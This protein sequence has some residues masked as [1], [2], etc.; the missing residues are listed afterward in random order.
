M[1]VK[2]KQF[3]LA[4]FCF[5]SA[6]LAI[7]AIIIQY[8][9]VG[10]MYTGI[11]QGNLGMLRMFTNDGNIFSAVAAVICGT[12]C[13]YCAIK[14]KEMNSRV[15]YSLRL[16]A[17]VSEVIIFFI[18][19][20]VLMPM[21]MTFLLTG[22]SMLVLHVI[23]PLITVVTFLTLDKRS[24]GTGK[25]GYLYGGTPVLVYGVIVLILCISKVWTGDMIPYPF[26]RV[27]DNPLW[28]TVVALAGIILGT[29]GFSW[30]LDRIKRK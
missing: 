25:T 19:V 6:G 15:V 24:S 21:G 7:S 16:M 5:I 18:V 12:Y 30:G 1:N 28:L 17:A 11:R 23:V 10:E 2:T 13:I 9:S 20:A 8:F 29:F 4:V 27:Y 14:N 3:I 22:Y 26:F